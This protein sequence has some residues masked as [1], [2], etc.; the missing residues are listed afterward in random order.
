M[1]ELGFETVDDA[2]HYQLFLIHESEDP[3]HHQDILQQYIEKILAYFAP[4]LVSYIWQ[5]ES[6]NLKYKPAKGKTGFISNCV[7]I[8][9]SN[10][11]ATFSA[12]LSTL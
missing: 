1:E 8:H 7:F 10:P 2:V 11:T 3:E 6:F 4:I 5:N 9:A 12:S